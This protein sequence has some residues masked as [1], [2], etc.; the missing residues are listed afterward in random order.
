M[1]PIDPRGEGVYLAGDSA[2]PKLNSIALPEHLD[3]RY[4]FG[5]NPQAFGRTKPMLPAI[6]Q[7]GPLDAKAAPFRASEPGIKTAGSKIWGIIKKCPY[8]SN[9]LPAFVRKLRTYGT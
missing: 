6:P 3:R 2:N 5:I 8:S 7:P 4:F 9:T 1:I